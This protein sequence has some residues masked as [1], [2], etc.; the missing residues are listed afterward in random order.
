MKTEAL[1]AAGRKIAVVGCGEW[2]F[3]GGI[4]RVCTADILALPLL[5]SSYR[6][7]YVYAKASVPNSSFPIS[8]ILQGPSFT[9]LIYADP[10]RALYR[11]V[12]MKENLKGTPTGE[13]KRGYLQ[14]GVVQNVVG[15]LRV[16]RMPAPGVAILDSGCHT[17]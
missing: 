7:P 9:G 4:R 12:E 17:N 16:G 14:E 8:S 5:Y 6:Y 10:D 15:V 11:T 13:K 3:M 2:K 1:W